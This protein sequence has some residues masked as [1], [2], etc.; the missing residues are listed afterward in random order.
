MGLVSIAAAADQGSSSPIPLIKPDVG[1]DPRWL[2][3]L[4][5]VV[6]PLPKPAELAARRAHA[7]QR[8]RDAAAEARGEIAQAPAPGISDPRV[9][10]AAETERSPE[11]ST[12]TA[13]AVVDAPAGDEPTEDAARSEVLEARVIGPPA[14]RQVTDPASI[15]GAAATEASSPRYRWHVQLLA[16]RSLVKVKE[17]S[18][19]FES[20]YEAMLQ[21]RTLT[22]NQSRYGDA[23]DEFYRLRVLDWTTPQPARVWCVQLRASGHQCL[24]TRVTV[25]Q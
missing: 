8:E 5:A 1:D 16:G 4:P 6:L 2:R 11:R 10:E 15:P 9:R 24:V 19:D 13:D 7:S 25:P 18:R 23:R 21:G 20:R 22:I 14:T 3:Q 12:A 17:D